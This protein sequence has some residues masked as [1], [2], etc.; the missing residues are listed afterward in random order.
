MAKLLGDDAV[1]AR[2]K[3][4]VNYTDDFEN[5]FKTANI[6]YQAIKTKCISIKKFLN[7]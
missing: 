6:E 7:T 5:S 1:L 2:E 3:I 4:F